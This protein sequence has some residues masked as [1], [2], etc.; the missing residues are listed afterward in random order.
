MLLRGRLFAPD[1]RG[2]VVVAVR[3]GRIASIESV[4]ADVPAPPFA[5]VR[6][7]LAPED[8][9][10]AATVN[11]ARVLGLDSTMGRVEVGR[12]AD[13]VLLDGDWSA[14]ATIVGGR[15]VHQRG[16]ARPVAAPAPVASTPERVLALVEGRSPDV[17]R[18]LAKVTVTP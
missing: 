9:L 11:P 8:A 6:A 14:S 2:H 13:L 17:P 16:M 7:G 4:A 1:P 15:L 5:L 10:R 3:E 12:A 18:A